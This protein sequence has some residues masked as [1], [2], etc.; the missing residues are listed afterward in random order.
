VTFPDGTNLNTQDE[1]DL[2]VEG[3]FDAGVT[4]IVPL[5]GPITNPTVNG[6]IADTVT[7]SAVTTTPLIQWTPPASLNAPSYYTVV[8]RQFEE[9]GLTS[10]QSI[11]G[12]IT[13]DTQVQIP[14]GFLTPGQTYIARFNAVY[15]PAGGGPGQPLVNGYPFGEAESLTLNFSP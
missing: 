9:C 8:I 7:L 4:Q 12:V 15:D 3:F 14:S 13:R 11:L 2:T 1:A 5:V 10:I 6:Q